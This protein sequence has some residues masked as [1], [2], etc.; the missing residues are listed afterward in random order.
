MESKKQ[1]YTIILLC[2]CVYVIAYLGRYSYS[3]NITLVIKDYGISRA[4]AGLVTTCFF[5]AYG[6]GQVINGFMCKRY[7]KKY[8]FPIVLFS[9]SVLNLLL[10]VAP[11]ELFKYMWLFNGILQSC[12]WSSIMNILGE[13]IDSR[14]IDK[15]LLAMGLTASSGTIFAYSSSAFFAWLGNYRYMFIFAA[16]AM[17]IIAVIWLILFKNKKAEIKTEEIKEINKKSGSIT[18][19]LGIFVALAVFAV[20]DNLT[21]DGLNTWVPVILT[22]KYGLKSEMSI[23]STV[24]LPLLGTTGSLLAVTIN[25][26]IKNFVGMTTIYFAVSTVFVFL[27][28]KLQHLGPVFMIICFGAIVCMMHSVNNVI[29]AIAPLEL[30]NKVE[31]GKIAGLLN[32]FC[33][34]GSTISS[35]GLGLIADI[36]GWSGVFILILVLCIVCTL[37]GVLFSLRKRGE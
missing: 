25:K 2:W 21:K 22:E 27:I 3:A 36:S 12:L 19:V 6:I 16:V 14:N 5:F 34:L 23:F 7:N 15:A 10:L 29:T 28:I 35:Y 8:L 11:F 26:H 33:Y 9:S 18:A 1:Q 17:S 13:R 4:S 31:P 32:G 20:V 30:R 37:F 24:V